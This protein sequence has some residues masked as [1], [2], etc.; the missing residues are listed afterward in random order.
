[1][2]Y[3]ITGIALMLQV[4]TTDA[5]LVETSQTVQVTLPDQAAL[6]RFIQADEYI[7]DNVHGTTATLI[8]R[9]G[10]LDRLQQ[11]GYTYQI[12]PTP[13]SET[14]AKFAAGYYNYT[15]LTEKLQSCVTQHPDL[16][17]LFSIGQSVQGR[18][19][20]VLLIS[21]NPDLQ[22]D[23]PEFRYIS[24]MHGNEPVGTE[25]CV[26]F[27]DLLLN[28]YATDADIAR[29]IDETE[30][31]ILPL[32][33]PDGLELDRRYNANWSDLNRNFPAYPDD[34]THNY[35]H[36]GAT[37][38]EGREP[39]TQA[40]MQWSMEN[41]FVLS[42]DFHTGE[43]VVNYPYDNDGI[44][45]GQDAPTPDDELF[46][47]LCL[48]YTQHNLP[49]YNS[50]YFPQGITNGTAW[51]RTTGSMQDWHYRYL[52][53]MHVII[54]VY[55]TKWPSATVLP[56]LWDDNRDAMLAY[57][58]AIH[59]GIRG[60]VQDR[61]GNT[62]L[63]AQIDIEN[64]AQPTYT[65]PDVGDYHRLLLPG[66]YNLTIHAPDYIPYHVDDIT[67]GDVG[68]PTRLDI[69]LSD[70]DVT[71]DGNL[72]AVDI[73]TTVNALLGHP[74]PYN[75]DVDG[76]GLTATDLQAVINKTLGL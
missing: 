20:W 3:W 33:N 55:Q 36:D 13:T 27:I 54:E 17:R 34:F 70:G 18:E 71:L 53:C 75:C 31:S 35:Y 2:L 7:I 48:R 74:T 64:N 6:I 47:D 59:R 43:I 24:T 68:T 1:M 38:L 32:L 10:D 28:N 22:E 72:N 39:E 8:T 52:S 11:S 42:A 61:R 12:L 60:V 4:A 25:L 76:R 51:Y 62:P 29:L 69:Q 50:P 73:Q 44:P 21:D 14:Q 15:T 5:P 65:D 41:S 56:T 19:L 9:P 40:A 23:E 67:A 57:L 66:T 30:I 46:E 37:S 45:S 16:C 26:Y 63:W 49:M 58:S